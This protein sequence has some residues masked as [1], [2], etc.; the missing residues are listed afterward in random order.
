MGFNCAAYTLIGIKLKRSDVTKVERRYV[1]LLSNHFSTC[2][3]NSPEFAF[4]PTCGGANRKVVET[5]TL[6]FD[7][8]DSG[9]TC[10]HQI[11]GRED[12]FVVFGGELVPDYDYKSTDPDE[13]VYL[14][15][16]VARK[17]GPRSYDP[18]EVVMLNESFG[19]LEAKKEG[20]KLFLEGLQ[21]KLW[22][23]KRFGIYTLI[24]F[25]S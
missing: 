13:D 24:S 25:S 3:Q 14:C 19:D 16:S 4:C 12:L 6:I 1:E 8:D 7:L 10:I 23:E 2:Y 21:P 17:S 11:S 18:K 15:I 5:I 20:L 9:M 22:D